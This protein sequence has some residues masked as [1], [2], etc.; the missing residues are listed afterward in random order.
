MNN[1]VHSMSSFKG[2]LTHILGVI[3]SHIQQHGLYLLC[4]VIVVAGYLVTIELT[5]KKSM[6]R[7]G[8]ISLRTPH[9][10]ALT[11]SAWV[12]QTE[13]FVVV[14]KGGPI[15]NQPYMYKTRDDEGP[16]NS[17][18]AMTIK[19]ADG[20]KFY[21]EY[22]SDSSDI[23]SIGSKMFKLKAG[24]LFLVDLSGSDS[25]QTVRQLSLPE[26]IKGFN[27]VFVS[28][29]SVWASDPKQWMSVADIS[30]FVDSK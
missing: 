25:K 6:K 30:N 1:I 11:D 18:L 10:V 3:G 9:A 29:S 12:Y 27:S 4:T 5:F 2:R 16:I 8:Q 15:P 7:P 24:S 21:L 28:R 17:G 23:I 13:R 14:G 19:G 20:A 26:S 22:H